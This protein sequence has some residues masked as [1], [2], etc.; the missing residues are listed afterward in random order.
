[1]SHIAGKVKKWIRGTAVTKFAPAPVVNPDNDVIPS[2]SDSHTSPPW[3]DP[4][5]TNPNNDLPGWISVPGAYQSKP[6]AWYVPYKGANAG[7]FT[8]P[9]EWYDYQR[10]V[11]A[12]DAN[13]TAHDTATAAIQYVGLFPARNFLLGVSEGAEA[14]FI[15]AAAMLYRDRGKG[16]LY[17]NAGL[18]SGTYADISRLVNYGEQEQIFLH[19]TYEQTVADFPATP[20]KR[21]VMAV[22]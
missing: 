8:T 15:Y 18:F 19:K 17:R 20:L 4:V 2:A 10:R 21:A 11:D 6:G 1:M 14:A 3:Y 12:R 7:P 9:F 22:L 13:L 16:D 5:G